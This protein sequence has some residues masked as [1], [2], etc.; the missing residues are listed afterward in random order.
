MDIPLCVD[1]DG[2]LILTDALVESTLQLLREKPWMAAALPFW[3]LKGRAGIKRKISQNVDLD[4]TTL[5]YYERFVEWLR[6]ERTSG[7]KIVL[8]TASDHS[9]AVAVQNHLGLF[10]QVIGS[11]GRFNS[12]GLNKLHLLQREF[13]NEFEYAGNSRA[14]LA[15]WAQC[16]S[17]IVVNANDSVLAAA[18]ALGNV[19]MVF[20]R[21]VKSPARNG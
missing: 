5:P 16:R 15:I 21:P 17:A 7:R 6:G 13:G 9:I 2:T 14:D 4:A 19:R 11:D 20:P 1:L 18:Q 10:N 12:K 8:A 3:L